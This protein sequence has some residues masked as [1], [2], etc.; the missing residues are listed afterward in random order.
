M[1]IWNPW[2]GCHK[3]SDGCKNCYMYRRDAE[4]GKDSSVVEKTSSFDLPMQ[5]KRDGS[6]KLESGETV[7]ACMTSDF[8]V[9]E[10]DRWRAEAWEIIK[11]RQDLSFIITTKRINR[12]YV[13]LPKDWGKGYDNVTVCCT[14]EDQ[15][16]ADNRLPIMLDLPIKRMQIIHEPMLGDIDIEK[17]L[18]S[19]KISKVICGGESGD[20]ARICRYDWILH[21][22]EQCVKYGIPFYFKQTGAR[23]LK[24][25][26]LYNIPRNLQM[27]Q[28]DKAG[29][30]YLPDP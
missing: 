5:K 17:Y 14:C 21:T 24:D 11:Q 23:F 10:A 30:N 18:A 19:G 28:A 16:T 8:F 15:Q 1:A 22:R 3:I 29:I 7:F 2:H 26:R 12:F 4:F 6:Y 25:N 27:A 20:K 13:N 9:E